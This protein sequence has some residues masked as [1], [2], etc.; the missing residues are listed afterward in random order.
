MKIGIIGTRGIPN[1]Y[2]GFEQ[3]AEY[4]SKGLVERGHQV[5]VYSTHNHSYKESIWNGVQLIHKYN[6]EVHLGTF[7]QFIYDLLCILDSRRRDFDIVLQLGYTSNSIWGWLLPSSAR[8]FTNMD[9]LEWK[10]TKYS[11]LVQHFL[12]YA[13]KLAVKTSDCLI[14]DSIGIKK[15][16]LDKY[17]RNSEFIP[18]GTHEFNAPNIDILTGYGLAPTSYN[19]LIARMEPEN[20]IETILNGVVGSLSERKFLVIGNCKTN[21]FGR[22]L[23]SKFSNDQRI[24]FL[25]AI[26]DI[27]IL[28]NLRYFSNIYFHGHSVGGTNPSLLEAMASNSLIC[29]HQNPFNESVLGREAFYFSSSIDVSKIIDSSVDKN[30]STFMTRNLMKVRDSYSWDKIVSDYENLFTS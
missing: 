12:R 20:N 5:I 6:A 19:M 15:Y 10:R 14:S 13:E 29:A 23:L 11:R 8:I 28:N 26:Y 30:A 22:H 18:Y 2:G 17:N 24:Y 3:L 7:G 27:E 25:G 21:T 9:G 4:L 16:L 1:N